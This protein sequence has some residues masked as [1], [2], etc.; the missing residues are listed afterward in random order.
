[1]LECWRKCT[2]TLAGGMSCAVTRI[3]KVAHDSRFGDNKCVVTV[4]IC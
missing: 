3:V 2:N 1:M 4:W